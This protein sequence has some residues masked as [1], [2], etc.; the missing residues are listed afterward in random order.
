[1]K[2]LPEMEFGRERSSYSLGEAWDTQASEESTEF[3][4]CQELG[5]LAQALPVT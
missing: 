1:M 3:M 4:S 5:G 2:L